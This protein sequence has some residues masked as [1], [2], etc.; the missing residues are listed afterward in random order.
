MY[1]LI[2]CFCFL[3]GSVTGKIF[4]SP[5]FDDGERVDTSPIASGSVD[6][7][8]I[9]TTGSGSRYFLSADKNMQ[10]AT[11]KAAA[12]KD[13]NSAKP[14]ATIALT[15]ARQAASRKA[16][17]PAKKAPSGVPKIVK[18]RKNRDGSIT[19]FISGSPNFGEGEKV[20]TSSI[21]AGS[22]ESGEVVQTG[23]GSKYFLV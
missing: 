6:N 12:A 23:S 9:V 18:W 11:N 15:K 21:A 7:G 8:S 3:K 2:V 20:T 1:A 22:V 13:T 16:A 10:S 14:S 19:G 17:K 4:G 5:N